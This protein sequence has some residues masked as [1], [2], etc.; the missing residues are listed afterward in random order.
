MKQLLNP[1]LQVKLSIILILN[2][3]I[4]YG[5]CEVGISFYDYIFL[6]SSFY[7]KMEQPLSADTVIHEAYFES[8]DD[9]Y[10]IMPNGALIS[11]ILGN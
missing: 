4:Y 5:S 2:I 8:S 6:D 1:L 9:G 11:L 10:A 3:Y 7:R